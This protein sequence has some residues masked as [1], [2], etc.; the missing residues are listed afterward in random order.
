MTVV[1]SN[2]KVIEGIMR[3]ANSGLVV[4]DTIAY[5]K[6]LAEKQKNDRLSSV[7]ADIQELKTSMLEI[8]K[9]LKA[10]KDT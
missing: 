6:Y 1:D 10:D 8:L 4:T 3:T 9:I 5:K 7:E 2:G